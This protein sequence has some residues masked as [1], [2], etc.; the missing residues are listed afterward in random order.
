MGYP[1]SVA[2]LH[3]PIERMT[4]HNEKGVDLQ[5]QEKKRMS[6]QQAYKIQ[7]DCRNAHDS[8]HSRPTGNTTATVQGSPSYTLMF[9]ARWLGDLLDL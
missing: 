5:R 6:W 1:C 4:M 8:N 7:L 9:P 3:M 2:Q